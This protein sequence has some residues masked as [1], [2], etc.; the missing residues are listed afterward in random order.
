MDLA[1]TG[2]LLFG[3][4]RAASSPPWNP[5]F[6]TVIKYVWPWARRQPNPTLSFLGSLTD[7]I[8]CVYKTQ[9]PSAEGRE[10][11]AESTVQLNTSHICHTGDSSEMFSHHPLWSRRPT[12][13]WKLFGQDTDECLTKLQLGL[14]CH[15]TICYCSLKGEENEKGFSPPFPKLLQKYAIMPDL[16]VYI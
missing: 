12:E 14:M 9:S 13:Q 10:G 1:H 15:Y 16:S 5:G 2:Y 6:W 11:T 8:L 3:M 4:T 7:L